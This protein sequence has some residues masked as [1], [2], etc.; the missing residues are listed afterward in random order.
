MSA[1]SSKDLVAVVQLP[2]LQ[3]LLTAVYLR[4]GSGKMGHLS[5]ILEV[6]TVVRTLS[7]EFD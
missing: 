1:S 3:T 6:R 5:K 4:G 7:P 2:H